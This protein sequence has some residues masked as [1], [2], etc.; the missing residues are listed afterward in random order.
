[1]SIHCYLAIICLLFFS[2]TKPGDTNLNPNPPSPPPPTPEKKFLK[3]GL[4]TGVNTKDFSGLGHDFLYDTSTSRVI[5][6]GNFNS[7]YRIFYANDTINHI[8]IDYNGNWKI[9][10]IFQYN[11]HKNITRV[12]YKPGIESTNFEDPYFSDANDGK[13]L[14]YDSLV[15]SPNNRLS[16][17]WELHSIHGKYLVHE[18]L[19]P[20]P[21]ATSPNNIRTFRLTDTSKTLY[22]ELLL[23]TDNMVNPASQQL[24]F[25]TFV[26]RLSVRFGNS[27]YYTPM[28]PNRP[29][30][31]AENFL[32][33]VP[34]CITKY[35]WKIHT[36]STELD[37]SSLEYVYSYSNDRTT[38]VGTVP[39][40]HES[41]PK[42][43]YFFSK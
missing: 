33:L 22:Q 42:I 29:P 14:D 24:G 19:Y 37:G 4:I 36:G 23:T 28:V 27:P 5:N 38:F 20:G 35:S 15:Y 41:S 7:K 12:L 10:A 8:V 26:G 25:T 2:C 13:Y 3:K 39:N 32:P 6:S 9:S 30:V 40:A 16:E 11:Q 31:L 43:T 17:F 34:N 18:F 1:M 21:Q